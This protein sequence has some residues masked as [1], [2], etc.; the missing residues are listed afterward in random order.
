MPTTCAACG[1]QSHLSLCDDCEDAY[2]T[3]VASYVPH[4]SHPEGTGTG[5]Y[6]MSNPQ[7]R[8]QWAQHQRR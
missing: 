6:R 4:R 2:Q 7:T 8:H 3:Y 5:Y 1:R